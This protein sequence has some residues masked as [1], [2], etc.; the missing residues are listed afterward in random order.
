VKLLEWLETIHRA[1]LSKGSV[2]VS[3]AEHGSYREAVYGF[4]VELSSEPIMCYAAKELAREVGVIRSGRWGADKWV[5][6]EVAIRA[7]AQELDTRLG[8]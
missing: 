6:D 7:F 8:H 2:L 3:L 5:N 1:R 4:A